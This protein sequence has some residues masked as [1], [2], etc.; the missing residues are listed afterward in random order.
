MRWHTL[1]LRRPMGSMARRVRGSKRA[2]VEGNREVF[3]FLATESNAVVAPVHP[4]AMPV[5]LGSVLFE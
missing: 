5:I 3:G 2:P 4:R 1:A